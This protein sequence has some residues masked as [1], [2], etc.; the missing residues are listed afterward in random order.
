M[1]NYNRQITVA[2]RFE[3]ESILLF[4]GKINYNLKKV[5]I[6]ADNKPRP[7]YDLKITDKY[8]NTTKIEVKAQ[9]IYNKFNDY[10]FIEYE[11]NGVKSGI[12]LTESDVHHIYKIKKDDRLLL[13]N[14]LKFGTKINKK[15]D[16][17]LYIIPTN[18]IR[19]II[20]YE[21]DKLT[22]SDYGDQKGGSKGWKIPIKLFS[23]IQIWKFDLDEKIILDQEKIIKILE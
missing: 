20:Y 1:T 19:Y 2:S 23:D 14:F 4:T 12:D 15:I 10:I 11:Q 13:D 22:F 5:C 6:W 16:Y 7:E 18:L 21:K 3:T 8:N 9:T 17:T